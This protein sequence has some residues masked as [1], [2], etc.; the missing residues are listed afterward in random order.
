MQVVSVRH[1]WFYDTVKFKSLKYYEEDYETVFGRIRVSCGEGDTVVFKMSKK[2][3][4]EVGEKTYFEFLV[5]KDRT[6]FYF[7]YV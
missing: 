5:Q 3:F 1:G 6:K 7:E 2:D 4:W